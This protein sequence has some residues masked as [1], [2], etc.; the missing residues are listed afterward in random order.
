[1]SGPPPVPQ[2][3][4][5]PHIFSKQEQARLLVRGLCGRRLLQFPFGRGGVSS[6]NLSPP[7]HPFLLRAQAAAREKVKHHAFLMKRAC[8]VS[9]SGSGASAVAALSA[10][11]PDVLRHATLLVGELRTGSL[12]PKVYYELYM[13]V[14]DALT[15]LE[16]HFSALQVRARSARSAAMRGEREEVGAARVSPASCRSSCPTP[17]RAPAPILSVRS[18]RACRW[19]ACTRPCS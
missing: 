10:A 3:A 17:P 11:L 15:F 14:F 6:S 18:A 2:M 19:R 8:D 13:D 12:T 5:P 7:S 4:P 9:G 1:M 16:T